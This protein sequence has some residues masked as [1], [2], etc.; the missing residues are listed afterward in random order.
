MFFGEDVDIPRL[1]ASHLQ[2]HCLQMKVVGV[3]W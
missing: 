2:V 3:F 1:E